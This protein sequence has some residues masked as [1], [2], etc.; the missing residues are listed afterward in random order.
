MSHNPNLKDALR[1]AETI[2]IIVE[3]VH[4]TGELRLLYPGHQPVRING[5]RKDTP[6]ALLV[7]LHAVQKELQQNA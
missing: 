2:G 3:P 7:L 5:R 1:E 4:R 6:R